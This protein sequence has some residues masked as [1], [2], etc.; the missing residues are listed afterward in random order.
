MG[1]LRIRGAHN[2][3]EVTYAVLE[4]TGKISVIKKPAALPVT[5]KQMNLP[6][7]FTALPTLLIHDGKIDEENLDLLGLDLYWL[8]NKL[9]EKG[10]ARFEDIFLAVLQPDG[11]LY[12]SS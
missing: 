1:Q 12:L 11:T 3:S 8:R 7:K 5:R 10:F 2:L 4:P 9:A 6:P